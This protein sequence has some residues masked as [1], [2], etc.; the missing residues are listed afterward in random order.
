MK[1]RDEDDAARR[2]AALRCIG[3]THTSIVLIMAEMVERAFGY[4]NIRLLHMP[5]Y[6]RP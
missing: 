6:T 4:C 1:V 3:L 2:R 5:F